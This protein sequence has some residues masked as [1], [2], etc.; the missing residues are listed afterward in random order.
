MNTL[1]I[2]NVLGEVYQLLHK[3]PPPLIEPNAILRDP[4]TD[5]HG[6][7]VKLNEAAAHLDL[8]FMVKTL[9]K[10]DLEAS[11][12]ATG[13]P[14]IAFSTAKGTTLPTLFFKEKGT[15]WQK[16]FDIAQATTPKTADFK[17]L[18]TSSELDMTENV[19]EDDRILI[20]VPVGIESERELDK[21]KLTPFKRFVALLKEERKNIWHIYV[22]AILA[23]LLSL[24]IPL[25]VQSV[26]SLISGGIILRPVVLLTAF[27]VI[28]VLLTGLLQV[29][30][31]SVVETVQQ[32]IFART[33]INFA[34][35]IPRIKLSQLT[36]IYAPELVNRFFDILTVQKSLTK[37]LV[38]FVS[39]ILQIIF[40][41]LLLSLYHPMFIFFGLGLLFILFLNF[42]FTGRKGLS[43]SLQESKYK[44]QIAHW[45]EEL[46][47]NITT[48]KIAG[49]TQ[50]PLLKL[51]QGL[52]RYLA[53]RKA[54]F[55]VL[56]TQYFSFV[57]FKTVIVGGLLIMGGYLVIDA[58]I[59]V[60]QFVAAEI[61]IVTIMAAI[62]K[63]ILRLDV[64]YDILTAVEKIG[65]VTDLELEN[66]NGMTISTPEKKGFEVKVK[67]L[68]FKY[69]KS[70][71][72]ALDE[73]SF[74]LKPGDSMAI[75]GGE[76]SGKTTLMQMLAGMYDN[77]EGQ[78]AI[79]DFSIKDVS[80]S[81]LRDHIG[82]SLSH[83]HIFNGSFLENLTLG[84]NGITQKDLK[85]ALDTTELHDLVNAQPQGLQT[86]LAP[87]GQG[88]PSS[89]N[90]RIVL[91]RSLLG[92]PKM[93][94]FDDFF[95]N[96]ES[97]YKR[98]VLT[99]IITEKQFGATI[100][101]S[102]HDP[103]ILEM[104]DTILVLKQ[105]KIVAKGNW[106]SLANDSYFQCL[107]N[108]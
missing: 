104:V 37:I 92:Q 44:Y 25:G 97:A 47:R 56:V 93:I 8:H 106:Q 87:A 68:T 81:A 46:A 34:H 70:Q 17:N 63:L 1:Q 22:Y 82:D 51:E 64:I 35:R 79:N 72:K 30:Q 69:D 9:S 39:A 50:L 11:L 52:G 38:E 26:V 41:L 31:I 29:M 43:T 18:L 49:N 75:V 4:V 20:L 27:V 65:A 84:R 71:H 98:R 107:I 73:V 95:F 19:Q 60:G 14:T 24:T 105:G 101:A 42:Y 36:G 80:L 10:T 67:D 62:E 91:T 61:V 13:I 21:T 58:Q 59:S 108:C 3:K 85:K 96:L 16:S 48:F 15:T 76:G 100:I 6:W 32:R 90:K 45:L 99:R 5:A 40:G 94:L 7:V 54:H 83:E 33:A 2:H 66:E 74:E 23:G 103:I 55:K 57:I 78:I 12:T 102:S 77:F 89:A 28:G 88:L 53:R 86:E